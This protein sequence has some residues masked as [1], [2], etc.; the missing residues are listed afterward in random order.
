MERGLA[1]AV[2]V[3]LRQESVNGEDHHQH[4]SPLLA[5]DF[6]ERRVPPDAGLDGRARVLGRVPG[7]AGSC[8]VVVGGGYAAL[9]LEDGGGLRRPPRAL[10]LQRPHLVLQLLHVVDGA[11]QQRDLV[12]LKTMA[13][14]N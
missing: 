6:Q 7:P 12:C 10:L 1:L 2:M 14:G 11:P 5:A 9:A 13:K 8:C 4:P 3:M